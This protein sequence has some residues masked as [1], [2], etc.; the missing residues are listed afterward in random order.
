MPMFYIHQTACISPQHSF[1]DVDLSGVNPPL[2]NK[3][4]VME[5]AYEDIPPSSLRRMGKAVR[6]GIGAA[7]PL[8]SKA[9]TDGII[10]AT[11]NGGMEDCI[12][13]LNQMVTYDEVML[14]PGNFVQ[15]TP[16]S[17]AGQLGMITT[18]HG[19]NITHVHRGLAFENAMID[20]AMLLKENPNRTYLLGGVDEISTFDH[21][22]D[23][24][25][26][27]F[28]ND[29]V[30]S[31]QLYELDSPGTIAGEG[32]SMFIVNA[33]PEGAGARVEDLLSL[34]SGDETYMS[35][36]LQLF[37]DRNILPVEQV[38]LLLTGENGDNRSLKY[39]KSCEALLGPHT[40]IGRFK[41][42]SGEYATA[43]AF[44]LWL[45]CYILA[46][47]VVPEHVIKRKGSRDY[48]RKILIYNNFKNVQHSLMLLSRP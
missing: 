23:T 10:L 21:N 22:I 26:G 40:T 20:G 13:F 16:N 4:L 11:A 7:L 35:K 1:A 37:L 43:S 42:M 8:L 46:Q 30:N 17:I 39:F 18:N 48:I 15:S 6:T 32:A 36:Q 24:L 29:P 9:I 34:H 12:K 33:K 19:Y 44:A 2:D 41:H 5:P 38:D 28:K 27:W 14:T 31:G 47:Q 45:C 3:L 25:A